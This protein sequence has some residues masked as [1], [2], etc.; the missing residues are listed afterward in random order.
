MANIWARKTNDELLVAIKNYTYRF[1]RLAALPAQSPY[2]VV[3]GLERAVPKL[4]LKGACL[5]SNA[6]NEYFDSE[7]WV[8]F[9]KAEKL[10]TNIYWYPQGK[11]MM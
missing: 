3:E 2:E 8:I 6:E 4:G 9:E 7:N 10:D 1:V 11:Y 5:T